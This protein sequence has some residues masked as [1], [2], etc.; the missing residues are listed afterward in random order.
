MDL[1][2]NLIHFNKLSPMWIVL[3]TAS[4]TIHIVKSL[5]MVAPAPPKARICIKYYPPSVILVFLSLSS[6]FLLLK[7]FKNQILSFF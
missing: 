3:E 2:P 4:N 6:S 7:F 1:P 5:Q